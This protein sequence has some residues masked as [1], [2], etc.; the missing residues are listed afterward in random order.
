MTNQTDIELVY[1]IITDQIAEKV[2]QKIF[3][4]YMLSSNNILKMEKDPEYFTVGTGAKYLGVS[5][6]K[7]NGLLSDGTIPF[8]QIP[9][10]S[11]KYILKSD[12]NKVYQ[13]IDIPP[14][15]NDFTSFNLEFKQALK[16]GQELKELYDAFYMSENEPKTANKF[17][18]YLWDQG[19]T[20]CFRAVHLKFNDNQ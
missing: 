20:D 2:G 17:I 11:K 7:F 6:P 13:R 9:G 15:I 14:K 1:K 3:N 12:L 18:E 8:F 10:S 5:R 16:K 4:Q 19:Y